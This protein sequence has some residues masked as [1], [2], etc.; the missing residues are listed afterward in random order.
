MDA[1]KAISAMIPDEGVED[2]LEGRAIRNTAA[3][4]YPL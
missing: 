3:G 2:Y 1:G 4:K